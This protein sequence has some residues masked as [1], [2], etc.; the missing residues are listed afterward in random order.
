MRILATFLVAVSIG[1]LANIALALCGLTGGW[2]LLG[3]IVTAGVAA[4]LSPTW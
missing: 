4:I 1:A 3:G 2:M